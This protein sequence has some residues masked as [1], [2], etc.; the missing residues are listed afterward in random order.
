LAGGNVFREFSENN[1]GGGAEGK[2]M[3]LGS[4]CKL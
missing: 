4:V 1:G 2:W 3:S